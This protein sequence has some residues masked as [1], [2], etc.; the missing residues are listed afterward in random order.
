MVVRIDCDG[1]WVEGTEAKQRG[2]VVWTKQDFGN[3][4]LGM[5]PVANFAHGHTYFTTK[6]PQ[7]LVGS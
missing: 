6:Q 4:S 1:S 2:F 5:L 7:R 3:V